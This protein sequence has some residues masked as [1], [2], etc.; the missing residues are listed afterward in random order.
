MDA[1]RL[2]RLVLI[3][4]AACVLAVELL[5][6]GLGDAYDW[7]W[8][9]VLLAGVGLFTHWVFARLGAISATLSR[10]ER[11]MERLIE[12]TAV[13][14]V[15]VGP[16][17]RI[18]RMNP[19][20]RRLTGYTSDELVG[21]GVCSDLFKPGDDGQPTCFSNCLGQMTHGPNATLTSMT[22]RTRQG[23]DL[24]VALGVTDL[25]DGEFAV[26]F[27]DMSERI[28][29]ERE[30]ARRRRQAEAL[31]QVGREMAAVV[32]LDR[33]LER[34]LDKARV[35]MEADVAGWGTLTEPAHELTW[36]AM[37]GSSPD[38]TEAPLGLKDSVTGRVLG[39]GRAYVTQNLAADLQVNEE[40]ANLVLAEGIQAAMAVPLKVRDRQYGVLFVG[41]RRRVPMSD[42]DLLLLSNLGSHLS[43][44]VENTDL[45]ARMQHM[46]ALEERQR[47][48]R[49]VHDSFG[50][51]LTFMKMRL[52][53]MEGMARSGDRDHLLSEIL[54]VRSVLKESHEEV[55]RSI[56][57]L[58]E[59]GPPLTPLW[60]R[61]AEHMRLFQGQT[62]IQVEMTGREAVPA[63]LPERVED[64]VTRVIQEALVNVRN[65]SGAEHVRFDA[66]E[67]GGDLVLAIVD[68]G[69]GFSLEQRKQDG[70]YH[71]GL[72]IMRER[73]ESVGGRLKITSEEG[74]GTYVELAVPIPQGGGN[75]RV[76]YQGL[77]GR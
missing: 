42:E 44:A 43:I 16:G 31:Y 50:Q 61:W 22:L 15:L 63:H 52:H 46:A 49:E 23:K 37:V 29:L 64:Q 10:Q 26:I 71:F 57:Q 68:D 27:W 30:Q 13:G 12:A 56:Y 20:A 33:N 74:R 66:W 39:A 1:R 35:V 76:A 55:R 21:R 48:A 59:S 72:D 17:C 47:L 5:R 14:V 34:L 2:E 77:A 9:A 18:L 6:R 73:I 53:L 11:R 7:V 75:D 69:C 62:R 70:G 32:D 28:R 41:H 19:A 51:I 65:H 60:D 45:L 40:A 4:A 24:D 38:F 25:G 58:K 54:E 8:A 67:D 3:A 36:Q